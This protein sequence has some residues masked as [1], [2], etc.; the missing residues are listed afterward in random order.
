MTNNSRSTT[1]WKGKET[2]ICLDCETTGL[3]VEKDRII[4]VAVTRFTM[5]QILDSY[6]T[7]VNPE[8]DV[9]ESSIAIHHITP[10]MLQGKPTIA[11]V[12]PNLL[13]FIGN[14]II[15][16]HG[17]AFDIELLRQ[18]AK[19]LSLP[20]SLDKNPFI[21]TLRLARLYGD[22]PENSLETLRRHFNIQEEGAHR[23]MSDVIVNIDV[24][25]HLVTKF[26]NAESVLERLKQPIELRAMPLGKHK[27]RAFKEI[28]LDYL[29]WAAHKEFDQDL[30]FSIRLELK[31]RKGGTS[32][33]QSVN[34]FSSL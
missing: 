14:D 17:V 3:D 8:R 28:P 23:A 26:K 16:G 7:L 32:F 34:P 25:K 30:L 10:D 9:P 31:R 21:D 15:V 29:R 12:L 11:Q 19:R 1:G 24:F 5:D 18:A 20:C 22:S 27:G 6:E 13:S 2:F 4:E 33:S